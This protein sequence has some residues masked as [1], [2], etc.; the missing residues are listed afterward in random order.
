MAISNEKIIALNSFLRR[1]DF[2]SGSVILDLDGTALLEEEGKVFISGS[3]GNGLK[4]IVR[5]GRPVILNTLRFPLSV[6]K[7][8]GQEWLD[9]SNEK[10]PTICL[11]GGIFGFIERVGNEIVFD[12]VGSYPVRGEEIEPTMLGLSELLTNHVHDLVLFFYPRDWRKGEIIWVPDETKIKPLTEKYQ[13]A[14]HV[15]T[16]PVAE[17]EH[18]LK[19]LEACMIFVL[20][21]EPKD[22][23]MAYQHNEPASFINRAG[24]DKSFGLAGFASI[25]GVSLPDSMGAG[26]TSMDNFLASVGLAVVVGSEKLEHRGL[27]ETIA[28]HDPIELGE[29]MIDLAAMV[30][31][32]RL[33]PKNYENN[34]RNSG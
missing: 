9:L 6:I 13:S 20:V 21:N 28:V 11:N 23:L 19:D 25:L 16:C 27:R 30:Q 29:L 18:T 31:G 1:A 8:V 32:Q 26:N 7:T 4:E 12:E 15:I 22:K 14:S 17:L 2:R 10:I 5:L 33:V 34:P 3:V 24:V